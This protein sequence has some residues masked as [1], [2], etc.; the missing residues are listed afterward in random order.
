LRRCAQAEAFAPDELAAI[1]DVVTQIG[2]AT[3]ALRA[4]RLRA[5]VNQVLADRL[6]IGQ[7]ESLLSAEE[8]VRSR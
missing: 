5:I 3:D 7:L 4:A 6:G 1:A 2:L 8:S